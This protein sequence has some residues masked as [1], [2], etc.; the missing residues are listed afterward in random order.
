MQ[1]LAGQK[2]RTIAAGEDALAR[3]CRETWGGGA[4]AFSGGGSQ[5][6]APEV[7]ER[8]SVEVAGVGLEQRGMGEWRLQVELR[9]PSSLA[10]R[11]EGVWVGVNLLA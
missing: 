11:C 4:S 7:A 10:E 5:A 6:N 1:Q 3:R 9:G 8:E 2:Q